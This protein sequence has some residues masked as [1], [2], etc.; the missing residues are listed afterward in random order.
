M[1]SPAELETTIPK[2]IV[3]GVPSRFGSKRALSVTSGAPPAI[4]APLPN[5]SA[6][7]TDAVRHREGTSER[8]LT[9]E[10]PG[11]EMNSPVYLY[12]RAECFA[13]ELSA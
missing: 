13:V 3:V 6:H 8:T 5:R 12:A 11:L 4:D 1:R 2:W 10:R 7:R 9:F